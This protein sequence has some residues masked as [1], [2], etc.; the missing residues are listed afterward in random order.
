MGILMADDIQQPYF[1]MK[2]NV[3]CRYCGKKIESSS[4][5]DVSVNLTYHIHDE[6]S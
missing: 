2:V 3:K 5:A 1:S 4:P 6:H